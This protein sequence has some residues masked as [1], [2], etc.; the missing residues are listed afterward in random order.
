MNIYIFPQVLLS[1]P[2]C[3]DEIL[4]LCLCL[5]CVSAQLDDEALIV[6]HVALNVDVSVAAPYFLSISIL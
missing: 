3:S 1:L 6:L 4:S 2:E 5:P